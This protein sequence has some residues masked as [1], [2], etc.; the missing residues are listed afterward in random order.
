MSKWPIFMDSLCEMFIFPRFSR[1]KIALTWELYHFCALLVGQ[2]SLLRIRPVWLDFLGFLYVQYWRNIL[3][4]F[5]DTFLKFSA[6]SGISIVS[7][8][9]ELWKRRLIT[10]WIS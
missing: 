6:Q 2:P 9:G 4:Y 8:S 3:V 7:F 10:K 1:F 5:Q